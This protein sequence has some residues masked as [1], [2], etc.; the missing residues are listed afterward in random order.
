MVLSAFSEQSVFFIGYYECISATI[1][2]T[3]LIS[4]LPLL[5]SIGKMRIEIR[6]IETLVYCDLNRRMA[7]PIRPIQIS[8]VSVGEWDA[9][10]N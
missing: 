7:I 8:G 9:V 3:A 5:P 2:E 10:S 4:T 6:G 1:V